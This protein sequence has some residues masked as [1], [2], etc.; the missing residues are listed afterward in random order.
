MKKLLLSG[1]MF[2]AIPFLAQNELKE[3][4]NDVDNIKLSIK[5]LQSEIQSVKS[6]NIYLKQVLNINKPI[7]E[8]EKANTNFRITKVEGNKEKKTIYITFLVESKD[9]TKNARFKDIT[10]TDI[11]GSELGRNI[12]ESYEITDSELTVDVPKRVVM[13][14][15]YGYPNKIEN[16]DY[17]KIVKLLKFQ[18]GL[19]RENSFERDYTRFEFRDLNV[20][21]K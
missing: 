2:F 13:A 15:T 6:E 9:K 8:Q 14:F 10:I 1:A 17:P 16:E 3:L 21:W 4:R 20:E 5:N 19:Q 12:V 7:L 18:F 11:Y